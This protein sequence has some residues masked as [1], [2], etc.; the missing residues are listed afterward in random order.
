MEFRT[1]LGR[2]VNLC[3]VALTPMLP[4]RPFSVAHSMGS[5]Y[6]KVD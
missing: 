2:A 5:I 6:P 3:Q 4:E 1:D